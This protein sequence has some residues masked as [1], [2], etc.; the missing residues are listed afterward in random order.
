M[1]NTFCLLGRKVSRKMQTSTNTHALPDGIR[2]MIMTVQPALFLLFVRLYD[3]DMPYNLTRLRKYI[4]SRVNI[5]EFFGKVKPDGDQPFFFSEKAN[6]TAI[7]LL[8]LCRKGKLKYNQRFVLSRKG[9]PKYDRLFYPV[10]RE[11][12][13]AISILFSVE[14]VI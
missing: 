10:G 13:N 1:N 14:E 4:L 7:S 8:F 5:K 11:N 2:P 12:Q 3:T 6:R 9:K